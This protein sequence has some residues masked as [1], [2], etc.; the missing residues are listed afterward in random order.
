MRLLVPDNSVLWTS[1]GLCLGRDLT[2]GTEIYTVDADDNLHLHPIMEEPDD[3]E[4]FRTCTMLTKAGTHTSIPVYRIGGGAGA[5]VIG[6]VNEEDIIEPVE[7]KHVRS[8]IAAQNEAAAGLAER[9]PLSAIGAYYLGRSGLKPNKEALY[10]ASSSMESAARLAR[11]M[12]DN[13]VPEFGG[14]VSIMQGIVRLGYGKQEARHITLYRSDRLYKLRCRINLREGKISSAVYA[15]GMG[16]LYQ[17]LRGLFESGLEYHL[18]AFTRGA[19]G[20]RYAVLNVPWNSP[21]RNL[22]QSSCHLWKKYRLSMFKTKHQRSV[23][24]VKVEP[25]SAGDSDW[26]VLEIK[27]HVARCHEIEVPD[28]HSVIIDNMIVRPVKLTEDILDEITSDWEDKQEQGQDL[29][30]LRRKINSV[31]ALDT[32]VKP[33][34]EAVHGKSGIHT[35]GIIKNVSKAIESSTRYGLTKYAF[36]ILRDDTGEVKMKLWGE[37]ADNVA[38]GDILEISGAYTR[39]GILN[40]S[41]DGHAVVIDPDK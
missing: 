30:V 17:F 14:E 27:R 40:N 16:I 12:Q 31:A 1:S 20:E 23:G 37:L 38:E 13:L 4:E 11:E 35:V 28:E 3:P 32:I 36:V 29:A 10:F 34:R 22:L 18:D 6:Q 9:A 26:T 5:P 15:W 33:I 19:G 2:Y 24:E 7:D 8:F 21:T 39:N 41:M 25:Y